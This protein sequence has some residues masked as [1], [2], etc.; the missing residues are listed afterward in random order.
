MNKIWFI[1]NP[2]AGTGQKR[3][4]Q[5]EILKHIDLI[6]YEPGF[7]IT[8]KKGEASSFVKKR[9][10]EGDRIFIAVG[11]DG[12]VN[13]IAKVLV[14][15]DC[16]MGII[17]TG[18]GNGLARH[19]KLPVNVGG[20]V[21]IINKGNFIRMD[22]GLL[23]NKPF[24]CTCGVGFDAHVGHLFAESH[25]RGFF[26]Y[27]KSTLKEFYRY[28]PKKY[29]LINKKGK[30][31]KRRAFLVTFANAS[32]YG[33]NAYIAPNADVSDGLLDVCI[34]RPF[35]FLSAIPLSVRLFRRTI[36]QSDLLETFR[37]KEITLVR[38]KKGEVHFDGE[39]H[40]MGKKL[41]VKVVPA[42]L[43]VFVQK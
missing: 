19:L 12:T 6:K 8:G 35:P 13:E 24:F 15:T 43:N 26:S 28:K 36:H 17:P 1:I 5:D 32:Q 42:A 33:N 23:N 25:T 34:M 16:L 10:K 29:K 11:G 39:P 18:S 4:L 41:K 21:K 7:L 9:I 30:P 22:Y 27:I 37:T 38:K 40:M 20:S 14:K 31:I 2:V 3:K